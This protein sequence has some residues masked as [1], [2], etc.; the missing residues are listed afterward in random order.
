MMNQTRTPASRL[1]DILDA[2]HYCVAWTQDLQ[3]CDIVSDSKLF[4]AL[5]R[6]L[7]N[8]GEAANYLPI[9]YRAEMPLIPWRKV[10]ATRN[11]LVHRYW[12]VDRGLLLLTIH[13][14][15]PKLVAAIHEWQSA[16][17]NP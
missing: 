10:V 8:I 4:H 6:L 1:A 12:V 11:L 7:C 5:C 9:D 17:A 2:C 15:L 16:K 14:D 3:A 13:N